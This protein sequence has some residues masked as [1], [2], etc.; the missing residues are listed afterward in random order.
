MDTAVKER[1]VGAVVLVGLIVLL[2]PEM[3]SGPRHEA[4]QQTSAPEGAVRTY[5]IDL[6]PQAAPP[7]PEV[8]ASADPAEIA[9][10]GE[11]ETAEPT[12]AA[13]EPAESEAQATPA[14]TL[15]EPVAK[16][17]QVS[18]KEPG[19]T[20]WAVQLGSFASRENAQRLA[21]EVSAKG[22][23]AFVSKYESAARVRYR[24]RVG[25]EEERAQAEA[26][27]KRLKSDGR[28]V[29]VVSHP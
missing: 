25:P 26:L 28:Q 21:N 4:A 10:P 1:L 5:T 23:S 19:G 8:S 27:A 18:S 13:A 17:P 9:P 3:L 16:P 2:V 6:A 22:Y 24:V 15:V 29:S 20:G 12:P 14:E 7:E 11:P